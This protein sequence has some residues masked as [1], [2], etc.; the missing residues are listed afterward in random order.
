MAENEK[1]RSKLDVA[2]D[3]IFTL[4]SHIGLIRQHTINFILNQ[5]D[6]LH[7]QRDTEV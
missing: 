7:L 2:T 3:N 5:M 1:L 6:T 4:K